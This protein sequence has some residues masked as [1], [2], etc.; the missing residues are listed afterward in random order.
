MLALNV[1]KI[2]FARILATKYLELVCANL[3]RSERGSASSTTFATR[4]FLQKI[5]GAILHLSEP[6]G[7]RVG[8]GLRF[9]PHKLPVL[10]VHPSPPL[11]SDRYVR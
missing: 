6:A 3:C 2:I 5:K 8:N 4:G 7:R 9:W 11:D 1:G 10:L